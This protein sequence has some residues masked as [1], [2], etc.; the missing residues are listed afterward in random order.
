[1][2]GSSI[3][4]IIAS[5]ALVLLI[6]GFIFGWMRGYQKSLTR[7]VI[8]LIVAVGA[9]FLTP[10]ISNAVINFNISGFGIKA[11]GETVE[12]VKDYIIALLSQIKEVKEALDSS[13]TLTAFIQQMP[14]MIVNVVVFP[15]LFFILKWLSMAIY[16]IFAFTVFSKKKMENKNKI[17]LLG[18]G[19][20]TVQAL[21]ATLVL[22]VPLFGFVS[23]ASNISANANSSSSTSVAYQTS[24][25]YEVAESGGIS[26]DEATTYVEKYT[27]AFNNT[28]VVK[29][30]RA[31]GGEKLSIAV[32]NNLSTQ[33]INGVETNL[34]KELTTASKLIPAISNLTSSKIKV[35]TK[36]A[37]SLEDIIDVAYESDVLGNVIN[38][39]IQSAAKEFASDSGE[40]M[41]IKRSDIVS[42]ASIDDIL[43]TMFTSL[44]ETEAINIK[45]DIKS[46][47]KI[48]NTLSI[49]GVIDA[50]NSEAD[51]KNAIMDILADEDKSLIADLID[52]MANSSVL[53]SVLPKII[54]KGLDYVYEVLDTS[55]PEGE[56]E[57]YKIAENISSSAW[58]LEKDNIQSIFSNI[59]TIYN[60]YSNKTSTQS[61]IEV[62]SME[63][64]GKVFDS[65]RNCN[66]FSGAGK[67]IL[68]SILSSD[69]VS[70]VVSSETRTQLVNAWDIT[71]KT[72]ENYIDYATTFKGIDDMI[73]VAKTLSESIINAKESISTA[74]EAITSE[75][76]D[77][78][79][80][81]NIL[82]SE[83]LKNAGLD[84]STAKAVGD[85]VSEITDGLK[86]TTDEQKKAEIE[87]IATALDLIVQT[88][89]TTSTIDTIS[90]ESAT[91]IV[92]AISGS[93]IIL[94]LINTSTDVSG[95]VDTS[96][97]DTDTKTNL[98]SAID[99]ATTSGKL[100]EEQQAKLYAML[101]IS[102]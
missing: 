36:L 9:F 62:I 40:F 53:R 11:N 20:G 84:E 68:N 81:E 87:G 26:I 61:V 32:F 57:N 96:K 101:G 38:E 78:S 69:M 51:A 59:A 74:L 12:T 50:V 47:V 17:K 28:W 22:L 4:A 91:E 18:A 100:T 23:I 99:S 10:V 93:T 97:L 25:N 77:S 1:M 58:I 75:G 7:L 21:V 43:K 88:Q 80:M 79:V 90:Q 30:Y 27:T 65:M 14:I 71:D 98:Q 5:V 82:S 15:I 3:S 89:N 16:A 39:L 92:D 35:D 34:T 19:I 95:A 76:V 85:V 66:I 86:N 31:V 83:N 2:S 48:I 54:N 24:T 60:D 46:V 64:I 6:L 56:E 41:G 70:G 102:V 72:N 45:S 49:N 73:E 67:N 63:K 52:N 8:V 37:D 29:I 94:D 44:S 13:S 55:I 33:K 42:D